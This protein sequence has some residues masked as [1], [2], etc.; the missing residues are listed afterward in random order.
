MKHIGFRAGGYITIEAALVFPMV[1][2]VITALLQFGFKLYNGFVDCSLEEYLRIKTDSIEYNSYNPVIHGIDVKD[3]VSGGL[4][5]SG[6]EKREKNKTHAKRL[7]NEYRD[8]IVICGDSRF[9]YTEGRGRLKN[10]TVVR[11]VHVIKSHVVH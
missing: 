9:S 10:S 5:T 3:A 6:E 11:M 7:V 8:R 1:F 2:F 4:I